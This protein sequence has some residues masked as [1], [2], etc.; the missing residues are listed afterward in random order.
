MAA[1]EICVLQF[2]WGDSVD[3]ALGLSIIMLTRIRQLCLSFSS[4]SLTI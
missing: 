4:L 3:K 2:I 1:D